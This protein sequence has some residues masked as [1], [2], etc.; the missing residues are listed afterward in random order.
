[1]FE[2][3]GK[4]SVRFRW[5]II[6]FWIAA[7]PLLTANL[8][9]LNDVSKNDN[10]QFLPANSQTQKANELETAFQS[11]D[12][13]GVV[14]MVI[15]RQSG[16]L[17]EDDLASADRA[18]GNIK[19]INGVLETRRLGVSADGQAAEYSIGVSGRAAGTEGL[20]FLDEIRAKIV[21]DN[22]NIKIHLAGELAQSGDVAKKN[23]K[24]TSKTEIYNVI[25][26]IALLLIVFRAVLAPI[27]TLLP[28]GFALTIAQPLI[29]ESTK[30][31]V[32]VSFLTQILLIVVI[33]GAGADYGLFLV[34][35]VREELRKGLNK[36]E[37]VIKAV[38]R[39]G[40]SITFSAAT[41]IGAL[42][43]LGFA[44]FGLYRGLG[45]SLGIGLAVMLLAGL[46][47]LPA[48]L[49]ILGRAV[50]W[51]SKTTHK[52]RFG[53]WGRLADKVIQSPVKMLLAGVAI[54]VALSFGAIGYKT[55]G[56]VAVN[57]PAG[58]DSAAG[59]Q[60]LK[61]HFPVANQSPQLII[62]RFN[63]PVWQN[64][65]KI[66][67]AQQKLAEA[68]IF[69]AVS[70]PFNINGQKLTPAELSTLRQTDPGSLLIQAE[71]QFISSDNKTVQF[72]AVTNTTAPSGSWTAGQTTPA[73]LAAVSS[74][75][76][77][78]G[79]QQ[80]GVW[81][82]DAAM[83]EITKISNNDLKK[84]IPIVLIVIAVLLAILL[85]SLVAPWYLIVTV[86]MS[87]LA[88][89]GFAML[90]FVHFG[91]SDGLNFI[92][93]FLM[94]IFAMALGEDYNILVMSRIRE[95]AHK[96]P[97]LNK[98]VNKAI[99]VTGTT[100]TSAGIILAGT[101]IVFAFVGGDEQFKQIGIAVAFGILLDTFLVRTLLVP[102]IVVL[103]GQKNWWPSHLSRAKTKT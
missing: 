13:A 59:N 7:I 73:V 71:G 2:A 10:S 80:S 3:I 35:R 57:A 75:A 79:A 17:T 87:Y 69:K 103:L 1:M 58:S 30:I 44:S 16:K 78:A 81:G 25:F 32:D 23:Q 43:C 100:V 46:T 99:G 70:G 36:Q 49:A 98:A 37:A 68:P 90:V 38:A 11:K 62:L 48:L 55:S 56:F 85:R 39:V 76:K 29:A 45:P 91:D 93:P 28:A 54:L 53:L 26:I 15:L 27:V 67:V 4:F 82:Q 19:K 5:L 12:T 42:L 50:F 77:A 33:L 101:F 52:V 72:Y 102:S 24:A 96:T 41:V 83:Y 22:Q 8:P 61:E 66:Y 64:L 31:G 63:Q 84:I 21:T 34:F 60:I 51:P 86:L 88:A 9:K 40:E 65:D 74:A 6:L 92:L 18:L 14:N 95:E 94:F 47:L 97:N 20:K 89:L